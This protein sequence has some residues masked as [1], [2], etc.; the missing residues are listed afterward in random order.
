MNYSEIKAIHKLTDEDI[1]SWFGY[2]SG[3]SFTSSSKYKTMVSGI[4]HFY[5]RITEDKEIKKEEV[6]DI[7]NQKINEI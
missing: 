6:R 2:K 4:E 5:S 7:I 1:G 3:H